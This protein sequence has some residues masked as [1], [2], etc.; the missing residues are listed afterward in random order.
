MG[1]APERLF[2]VDACAATGMEFSWIYRL[3]TDKKVEPDYSEMEGGEWYDVVIVDRWLGERRSDF[4]DSFQLIWERY[5]DQ[6]S[7]AS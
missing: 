7:P 6:E 3:V 1:V 5:R 4:A 2:K